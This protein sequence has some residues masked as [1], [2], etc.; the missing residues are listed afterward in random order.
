MTTRNQNLRAQLLNKRTEAKCF[1]CRVVFPAAALT[2]EHVVPRTRGGPNK[3]WNLLLACGPCNMEKGAED[4][5]IYFRRKYPGR[6]L[7]KKLRNWMEGW[8][9]PP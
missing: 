6:R 3:P 1:Y 7:P 5:H 4:F 2:L 8:V 9:T